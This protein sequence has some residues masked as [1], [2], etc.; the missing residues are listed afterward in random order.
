[1]NLKQSTLVAALVM[2][3]TV[4]PAAEQT[5][6]IYSARH[7]PTD[8]LAGATFGLLCGLCFGQAALD[9]QRKHGRLP[10]TS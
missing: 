4:A 2:A 3:A 9:Y 1:M 7:Y 6:N 5:L 10:P 8:V